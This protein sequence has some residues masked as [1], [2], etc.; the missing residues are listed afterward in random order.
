MALMFLCTNRIKTKPPSLR[1]V[2]LYPFEGETNMTTLIILGWILSSLSAPFWIW[3]IYGIK[4]FIW[5]LRLMIRIIE[6]VIKKEP[7]KYIS[8]LQATEMSVA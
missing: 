8:V 6:I 5:L 3:V 4:V 1:A 2:F 7:N